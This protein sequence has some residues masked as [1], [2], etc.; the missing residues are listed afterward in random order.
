MEEL[1]IA[2]LMLRQ[3]SNISQLLHVWNEVEGYDLITKITMNQRMKWHESYQE[4]VKLA[5]NVEQ[6]D[7]EFQ[8]TNNFLTS[9]SG[10]G[11][12]TYDQD[13][14]R[15]PKYQN[16]KIMGRYIKQ[17]SRLLAEDEFRLS[18]INAI[19]FTAVK[20]AFSYVKLETRKRRDRN[21]DEICRDENGEKRA[22]EWVSKVL[23]E[24]FD[25]SE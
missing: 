2:Y 12:I 14:P 13:I 17:Q 18:K 15:Y 10:I 1:A 4:N 23:N 24:T 22:L 20:Q 16:D 3:N 11:A 25:S 9:S 6:F 8:I 21:S 19:A 7:L 5:S